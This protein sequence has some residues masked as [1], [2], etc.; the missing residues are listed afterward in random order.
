MKYELSVLTCHEERIS[1][2]TDYPGTAHKWFN[3]TVKHGRT[4]D[5]GSPVTLI[6]LTRNGAEIKSATIP[7]REEV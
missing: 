2:S 4:I 1:W 6:S 3:F 5:S 7:R